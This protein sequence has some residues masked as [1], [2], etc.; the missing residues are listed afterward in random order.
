MEDSCSGNLSVVTAECS[1]AF[2]KLDNNIINSMIYSNLNNRSWQLLKHSWF[3]C[4]GKYSTCLLLWMFPPQCNAFSCEHLYMLED[5]KVNI[6]RGPSTSSLGW[7]G[8]SLL[9]DEVITYKP[10]GGSRGGVSAC[11]P[12]LFSCGLIFIHLLY[13]SHTLD[14]QLF[15]T[16][17]PPQMTRVSLG[18]CKNYVT[19]WTDAFVIS[20]YIFCSTI[21]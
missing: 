13:S 6:N 2:C 11:E 10:H 3:L 7:T 17:P 1:P 18:Q 4:Q 16:P 15:P 8:P 5:K 12:V 21:P 19:V 14:T 9:R 20:A